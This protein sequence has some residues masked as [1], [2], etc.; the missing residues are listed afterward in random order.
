MF[1]HIQWVYRAKYMIMEDDIE[2]IYATLVRHVAHDGRSKSQR[3]KTTYPLRFSR[4]TQDTSYSR[5]NGGHKDQWRP[6]LPRN[7][8]DPDGHQAGGTDLD[9]FF[10]ENRKHFEKPGEPLRRIWIGP[11]DRT[12]DKAVA[13]ALKSLETRIPDSNQMLILPKALS[14]LPSKGRKSTDAITASAFS[15]L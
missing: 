11:I 6:P 10:N 14:E 7:F 15:G 5:L 1:N 3:R 13:Y 4:I 2:R 12:P 8:F 9:F